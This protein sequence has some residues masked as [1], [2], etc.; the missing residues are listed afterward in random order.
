MAQETTNQKTIEFVEKSELSNDLNS[1]KT[2]WY[3]LMD[4]FLVNNSLSYDEKE[5]REFYE[6]FVSLGGE[7]TEVRT[8]ETTVIK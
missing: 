4:G 5:A 7:T 3:T 1:K 2:F 6:K 8:L